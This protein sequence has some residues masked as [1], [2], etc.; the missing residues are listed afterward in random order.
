MN[1]LFLVFA[2]PAVLLLYGN[3]LEAPFILDDFAVNQAIPGWGSRPLGYTSFWLS[4]QVAYLFG[5]VF[6]FSAPFYF[7]IGNLLIHA[8]AATALFALTRALTSRTMVAAV[9]GIFFLVHPIQTQAVTYITQRFESLATLFMLLAALSYVH[10]R[11][12]HGWYWLAAT[13]ASAAAAGLTKETAV[14]LPVWLLLIEIVFFEGRSLVRR[15][16]YLAPLGL[17]I[18]YPAWRAFQSSAGTLTWVAWDRYFLTQGA[19]LTKY[20]MLSTWPEQQFLFYD[21]FIVESFTWTIAFQWTFVIGLIALGIFLVKRRPIVGFGILTFFVLLLPVTLIPLPDLIFEHRIY[22]AFAGLAIAAAALC[23]VDKRKSVWLVVGALAV[24]WGF[25]TIQRNAE[26][27]D[28]VT[29]LELHRARFPQNPDILMRLG[30]YY[31]VRGAV[32]KGIELTQEARRNEDRMNVYYRTMGKVLIAGNLTSLYL[33]K[34]DI[35]GALAEAR[36]AVALSPDQPFA[37]TSLGSVMLKTGDYKGAAGVFRKMT[38]K[39]PANPQGWDGLRTALSKSG[40]EAGAEAALKRY[41]EQVKSQNVVAADH[42]QIPASYNIAVIFSLILLIL[43][44]GVF[45]VRT[46]LNAVTALRHPSNP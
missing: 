40:D 15:A 30:S 5:A 2:I 29:F 4:Q 34:G 14:I 39:D 36:R 16:L 20:L 27:N 12:G 6:P 35:E 13:V 3:A 23:E 33:V 42:A 1:R 45:A 10:F 37:L 19:V 31:Y 43:G 26:W 41:D 18:F 21:F 22:P 28:E 11:K 25:K 24:L 46:V 44:G 38:E 8:L 17:V 9:A 7:R 32:N